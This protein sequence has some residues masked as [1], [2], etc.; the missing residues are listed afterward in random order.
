VDD[1]LGGAGGS[2]LM[3][4]LAVEEISKV[5]PS[6]AILVDV[7]NTLVNYPI[8]TYGSDHIKNTYLP[9]LTSTPSARTRCRSH[10]RAPTHSACRRAPRSAATA[11]VERPKAV[12][13]ERRRGGD[14]RRVRERESV[15]GLQGDHGV[16]RRAGF[17]G[18]RVGKKED[19]LGIRAS[20]TT[21]LILDDVEVPDANVLGPSVRV[22]D[23]DRD[24]ERRAHRDRRADDRRRRRRAAAATKYVKERTQFGKTLAEFQG[25]SSSSPR[26]ARSSRRRG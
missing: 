19:K 6:A 12:D 15:G 11:G 20:S 23:R 18:F 3:V 16:R 13:H 1:S 10:R 22:Q 2:L 24:A 5:D 14:L 7:Q 4:A 25:S 9:R 21:E 8:R 26:R 17:N